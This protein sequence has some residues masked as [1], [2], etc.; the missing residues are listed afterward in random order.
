MSLTYSQNEKKKNN[1]KNIETRALFFFLLLL[2]SSFL[3]LYYVDTTKMLNDLIY[4]V[5]TY[6]FHRVVI[7]NVIW[8]QHFSCCLLLC[9]H[10]Q[11]NT[12]TFCSTEHHSFRFDSKILTMRVNTEEWTIE[13]TK[14]I[15]TKKKRRE[16]FYSRRMYNGLNPSACNRKSFCFL[17]EQKKIKY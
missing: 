7:I 8:F 9:T 3:P 10:T 4:R 17:A 2:L 16:E 13:R 1:C 12:Y 11:T 15:M 6:C 5:Y 14:M